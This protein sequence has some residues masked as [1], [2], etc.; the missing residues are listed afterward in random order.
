[1]IATFF[2]TTCPT[3]LIAMRRIS[4]RL[5]LR[6]SRRRVFSCLLSRLHTFICSM[7]FTCLY[8]PIGQIFGLVRRFVLLSRCNNALKAAHMFG[9]KG[10]FHVV[11]LNWEKPFSLLVALILALSALGWLAFLLFVPDDRVPA[12]WRVSFLRQAKLKTN[13]F[14]NQDCNLILCRDF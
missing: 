14:A 3:N 10:P 11:Q 6:R 13:P 12:D 8:D 2:E 1:M 4:L 5:S 9:A 7:H